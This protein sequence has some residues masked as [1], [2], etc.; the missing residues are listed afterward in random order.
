[1]AR[2]LV[3]IFVLRVLSGRPNCS[4][5][6]AV[7]APVTRKG[8]RGEKKTKKKIAKFYL[9]RRSLRSSAAIC[10]TETVPR[11]TTVRVLKTVPKIRFF[12]ASKTRR[13]PGFPA[14]F[15]ILAIIRAPGQYARGANS[16]KSEFRNDSRVHRTT[17]FVRLSFFFS[18]S[19]KPGRVNVHGPF[20]FAPE[21][22]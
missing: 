2:S 17:F 3:S 20:Y 21:Y 11:C 6:P 19:I 9:N 15:S 18:R 22:V 12:F 16:V 5:T 10:R 4:S 1:M 13:R 7:F 8:T 14:G